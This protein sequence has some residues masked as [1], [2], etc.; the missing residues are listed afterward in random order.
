[1]KKYIVTAK[2]IEIIYADDKQ[3]AIDQMDEILEADGI[4]L[5]PDDIEIQEDTSYIG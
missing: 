1:M 5:P 3:H 2:Y 4:D